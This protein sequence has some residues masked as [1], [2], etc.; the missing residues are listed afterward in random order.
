MEV[1]SSSAALE[2][3]V[4]RGWV[5]EG[6]RFGD[7]SSSRCHFSL[8]EAKASSAF[9]EREDSSSPPSPSSSPDPPC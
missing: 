4:V 6:S 5:L 7:I 1:A 8:K 3:S 2:L 9:D